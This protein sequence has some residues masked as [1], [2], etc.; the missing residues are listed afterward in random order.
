MIPGHDGGT[1]AADR[2]ARHG[3]GG[4]RAILIGLPIGAACWSLLIAAL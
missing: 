2:A 3:L 4:A 1:S